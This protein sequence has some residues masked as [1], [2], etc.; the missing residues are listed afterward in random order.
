[1]IG[2]I[3]AIAASR[4]GVPLP[5]M[6]GPILLVTLAAVLGANLQAPVFLRKLLLPIL[7]VMLGSGFSPSIFGQASSWLFTIAILPLYVALAFGL[8]FTVYRKIGGY[9]HVT[10]YFS[11]APGGLNDMMMIGAEA[12]GIE[13][14]IAL[15]HASRILVVVGFVSFFFAVVLDVTATGDQSLY[16]TFADVPMKDLAILAA[17][18]VLG[19]WIGPHLRLPA[20]QIIG[21][22]IL[23]AVV[24]LVGLTYAP[25]PTLAVNAAQLVMGTVV[26]CRFLGVPAREILRDI[27]LAS[28]ASGLMLIVALSTA[29]LVAQVSGVGFGQSFLTFAPGGLPEMSLLSLAMGADVAYVVTIHILRI[30]LVIAVAPLVFKA[31]RGRF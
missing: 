4:L 5:W 21:P 3:G 17:C 8:A 15:A 14:R 16:V 29:L 22:M 25:P 24:H 2:L 1:M 11:S 13:R 20:P 26:G 23:S 12:G 18:A 6:L 9:D 27:A 30:T 28:L 10:A 19:A 31:I 7:G